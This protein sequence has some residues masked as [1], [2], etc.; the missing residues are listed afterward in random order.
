MILDQQKK[1]S[2]CFLAIKESISQLI[3]NKQNQKNKSLHSFISSLLGQWSSFK[4]PASLISGLFPGRYFK[5]NCQPTPWTLCIPSLRLSIT[6]FFWPSYND[7]QTSS[8]RFNSHCSVFFSFQKMLYQMLTGTF[9]RIN[10]SPSSLK[11]SLEIPPSLQS[12]SNIH[13]NVQSF[14][15]LSTGNDVDNTFESDGIVE[16]NHSLCLSPAKKIMEIAVL[17]IPKTATPRYFSREP[18]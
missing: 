7:I 14:N 11:S 13:G 9:L 6:E 2:C 10:H 18:R 16:T 5:K 8:P 12:I 15:F 1:L 17:D 4:K 3:A